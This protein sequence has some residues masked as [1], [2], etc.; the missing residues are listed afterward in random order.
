MKTYFCHECS[1]KLGY[2]DSIPLTANLTGS[3]YQ[4]GKFFKHT[5]SSITSDYISVFN[6]KDY[7]AYKNY[8]INT[9]A[10]G[11][12]QIDVKGRINVI[13]Y[14]GQQTGYSVKDGNVIYPQ[15]EGVKLVKTDARDEMHCYPIKMDTLNV[16]TC[17]VAGCH[18]N[19]IVEK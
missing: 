14:A 16:V 7:D 4:V 10:S 5:V 17:S 19:V 18:C 2:L 13:F 3:Q 1:Q 8:V 6:S 9:A 11:S 15:L 12:V